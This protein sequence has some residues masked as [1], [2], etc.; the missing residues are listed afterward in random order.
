MRSLSAALRHLDQ[1]ILPPVGNVFARLTR[2]ALRMRVFTVSAAMLAT[3]VTLV[4][5]YSASRGSRLGDP[6]IGDVV[7]VGVAEGD[8]IPEYVRAS[9]AQLDA[10]PASPEV[11]ALVSFVAY[12]APERLKSALKPA[13]WP[14]SISS[15]FARVPLPGVQTELVRLGAYQVPED[16]IAAMDSTAARKDDEAANYRK[17][18]E[19]ST[20]KPDDVRQVYASGAEVASAEATAYRQHCSCVYAAVVHASPAALRALAERP[21][22]RVV[23][24]AAEVR[25]LDRTVFLPPLPEQA[26]R[27]GPPAD[28]GG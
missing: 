23:D 4:A 7:R 12:L 26:D 8:A 22:V 3:T 13:L 6:T 2:G 5:V 17:L 11:Y 9:K 14:V 16:V 15:V 10:L 18:L 1:R 27:A 25:R 19:K 28:D 21:E 24:P 20:D